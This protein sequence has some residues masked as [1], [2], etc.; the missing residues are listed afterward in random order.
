MHLFYKY[1]DFC[2]KNW[3]KVANPIFNFESIIVSTIKLSKTIENQIA[4]FITIPVT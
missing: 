2:T 1:D 3:E 4:Y